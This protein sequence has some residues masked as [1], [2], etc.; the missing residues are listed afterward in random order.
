[1]FSKFNVELNEATI[2]YDRFYRIGKDILSKDKT[3]VHNNLKHYLYN[4]DSLSASLITS[5]WFPDIEADIFLSHSHADEDT[6]ISFAGWLYE[7]FGL[8]SFVDSLVWGYSDELLRII[9][10]E[11][12]K[13]STNNYSYKK[14]NVS[15]SHVHMMLSVALMKMID[16][17]ESVFFVNTPNSIILSDN[18]GN[19]DSTFSP[20]I[21]SEI[22]MTRMIRNK[23]L[24]DYRWN[25]LMHGYSQALRENT[26]KIRYNIT[27]DDF[28]DLDDRLLIEWEKQEQRVLCSF[29][30]DKLYE[31]TG[32]LEA[33]IN[34]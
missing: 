12:C 33:S 30:M 27:L 11:Y 1:M 32:I 21:Y 25:T 28:I 6:V 19:E 8:C 23:S 18:I 31:I 10:N 24:L 2:G 17:C 29:P 15:T 3:A 7:S 20:W 13:N 26:L 22:E 4:K 5:D 14:R 9:D 34:G 16:K